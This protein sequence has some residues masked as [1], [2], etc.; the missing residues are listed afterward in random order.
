MPNTAIQNKVFLKADHYYS[1]L[2]RENCTLVTWPIIKIHEHGIQAIN[3]DI[4]A[5]DVIVH[6][7][8]KSL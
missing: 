6:N 5:C 3:G 8:E 2:Q 1:S 4:Y 7:P